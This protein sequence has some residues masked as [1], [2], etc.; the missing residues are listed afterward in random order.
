MPQHPL[1]PLLEN[2]AR[3]K[4]IEEAAALD[5]KDRLADE[6]EVTERRERAQRNHGYAKERTQ[7][8]RQA[9]YVRQEQLTDTDFEPEIDPDLITGPE[10]R[11]I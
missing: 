3:A 11:D 4:Q 2:L 6:A 10:Q 8:A 5:V 7:I 1:A 9:L